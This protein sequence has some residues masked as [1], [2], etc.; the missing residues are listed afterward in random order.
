VA[1]NRAVALAEL[2]SPDPA[3]VLV[4]ALG[5]ESYYPSHAVRTDFLVRLGRSAEAAAAYRS[6]LNLVGNDA[7]RTFLKARLEA[8]GPGAAIHPAG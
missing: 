6:A 1:L 7:D 2:E 5:L 4:D 8:L 3:L